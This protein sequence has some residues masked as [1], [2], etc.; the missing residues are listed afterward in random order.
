DWCSISR[1]GSNTAGSKPARP[2]V[3]DAAYVTARK[4]DRG[5]WAQ[6]PGFAV[7]L[8]ALIVVGGTIGY[9]LL[10]GWSLWRSFFSTVAAIAT[11]E[12]PSPLSIPGQ[13]FTVLLL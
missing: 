13:V 1:T 9:H 12:L 3:V 2:P 7:A 10:E 8:L 6:G 11:L 5:A 4:G